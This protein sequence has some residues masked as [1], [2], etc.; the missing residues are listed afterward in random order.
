MIVSLVMETQ[1]CRVE[2][3]V[4]G[5]TEWHRNHAIYTDYW[6]AVI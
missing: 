3:Q 4:I 1:A 2:V 5:E 6:E